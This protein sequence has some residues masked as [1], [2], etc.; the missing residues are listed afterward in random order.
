MNQTVS[1][2]VEDFALESQR[3]NSPNF[4]HPFELLKEFRKVSFN[5]D[6]E[7]LNTPVNHRFFC[8]NKH[9]F[10]NEVD[11]NAQNRYIV[12]DIRDENGFPKGFSK[13]F[14]VMC[15]H[16]SIAA[17][18]Y[19][20]ADVKDTLG[21]CLSQGD[22]QANL[23]TYLAASCLTIMTKDTGV[24]YVQFIDNKD[25]LKQQFHEKY[26]SMV[27]MTAAIKESLSSME[28]RTSGVPRKGFSREAAYARKLMAERFKA[29]QLSLFPDSS[30]ETPDMDNALHKVEETIEK[31]TEKVPEVA[32]PEILD[33]SDTIVVRCLCMELDNLEYAQKAA[34]IESWIGEVKAAKWDEMPESELAQKIKNTAW[35]LGEVSSKI[36]QLNWDKTLD[37]IMGNIQSEQVKN[38][39]ETLKLSL[40]TK[41]EGR[42]STMEELTQHPNLT[43]FNLLVGNN[44]ASARLMV[45]YKNDKSRQPI[46]ESYMADILGRKGEDREE[47]ALIEY[48]RHDFENELPEQSF[49]Q[50]ISSGARPFDRLLSGALLSSELSEEGG[51]WVKDTLLN[52][53][54]PSDSTLRKNLFYAVVKNP[55]LGNKI[56]SLSGCLE[57]MDTRAAIYTGI[58]NTAYHV[59]DHEL[60]VNYLKKIYNEAKNENNPD[61]LVLASELWQEALDRHKYQDKVLQSLSLSKDL[62]DELDLTVTKDMA[63]RAKFTP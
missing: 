21:V 8:M 15:I 2:N 35:L 17:N 9:S 16:A 6:Q 7:E 45:K 55:D 13:A 4:S 26:P 1:Q 5:L 51:E 27:E 28:I 30:E 60:M 44:M 63:K 46:F 56:L 12:G 62:I 25:E 18:R 22:I 40:D 37:E 53:N 32:Y 34:C 31:K 61:M 19:K 24:D 59:K 57:D 3:L 10:V 38:L 14:A 49:N 33:S 58:V 48:L 23:D 43:A 54:P 20:Y 11:E 47:T 39:F 50:S 29:A 42:E 36:P 52:G 41:K